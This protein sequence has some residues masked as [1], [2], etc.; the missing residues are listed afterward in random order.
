[1]QVAG[2]PSHDA[3]LGLMDFEGMVIHWIHMTLT[4]TNHRVQLLMT[5]FV[6]KDTILIPVFHCLLTGRT[7]ILYTKI[8]EEVRGLTSMTPVTNM[9]HF[10]KTLLNSLR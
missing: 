2:S 8:L 6:E 1:M 7:E 4:I 3:A 10:E 5:I 9:Y